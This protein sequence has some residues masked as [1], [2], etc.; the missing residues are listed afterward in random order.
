[1]R[2]WTAVSIGAGILALLLLFSGFFG[3]ELWAVITA[4]SSDSLADFVPPPVE[5]V[6]APP[7]PDPYPVEITYELSSAHAFV[8]H[9]KKGLI[10]T[11]GDMN[12]QL[13]PASLT[14]M[15]TAYVALQYLPPEKVITVGEEVTWIDPDSSVANLQ[16]GNRLT[17]G[18]CVQGLMIQSGNDAAYTLAV[19]AGRVIQNDPNLAAK[20]AFDAFVEEMNRQA[21]EQGLSG[22]HFENPDGI[23]SDQHY[24]TATDLITISRLAMDNAVIREYSA[25]AKASVTYVSGQSVVWNNSNGMLVPEHAFY[26]DKVIGLKTGSTSKAGKCLV[27]AYETE[28]GYLLVGAMGSPDATLRYQ[29][30]QWLYEQFKDKI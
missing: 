22:T 13:R 1:M 23:D 6:P 19:N 24:T 9:E 15:F 8:Y 5:D 18:M 16:P 7:A 10:A 20:E 3:F 4:D 2:K 17:A 30:I 28:D 29:D 12:Q 14:K 25:M 21:Q 11:Y 26:C 27:T